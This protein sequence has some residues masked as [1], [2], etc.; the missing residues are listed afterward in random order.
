MTNLTKLVA[1]A[2]IAALIS[3]IPVYAQV[4]NGVKFTTPFAFY[5][6]KVLMPAG[7]YTVKQAQ[8]ESFGNVLIRSID[9]AHSAVIM[10]N[11]TLSVEPPKS[12]AV[13]FERYGDRLFFD[14]LHV[15]GESYGA[16]AVRSKYEKRAEQVA[17][18]GAGRSVVVAGQ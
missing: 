2:A 6:G 5:A 10:V 15:A 12:T 1:Q 3:A 14:Q 17:S 4:S 8:D 16:A 7:T 11:Q 18:S 9:S 13:S